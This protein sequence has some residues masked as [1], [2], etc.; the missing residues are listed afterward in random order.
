MKMP[1]GVSHLDKFSQCRDMMSFPAP[2]KKKVCSK[3][4]KGQCSGSQCPYFHPKDLVSHLWAAPRCLLM[5]AVQTVNKT[6]RPAQQKATPVVTK[7]PGKPTPNPTKPLKEPTPKVSTPVPPQPPKNDKKT[8]RP[9][10]SILYPCRLL[11]RPL[12]PSR[13]PLPLSQSDGNRNSLPRTP[14]L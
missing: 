12:C 2:S 7:Q 1:S 9:F 10:L 14:V 8:V 4:E 6:T 13:F 11:Y 3:Y 5:F